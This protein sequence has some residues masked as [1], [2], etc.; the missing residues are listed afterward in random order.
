MIKLLKNLAINF[1][2]K[3]EDLTQQVIHEKFKQYLK[4]MI[5]CFFIIMAI[6]I[7]NIWLHL[8]LLS[9][10]QL[11]LQLPL[12]VVVVVYGI[13][14]NKLGNRHHKIRMAEI[15]AAYNEIEAIHN[16]NEAPNIVMDSL[17]GIEEVP[18]EENNYSN[19]DWLNIMMG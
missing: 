7:C 18:N 2:I 11:F 3:D 5:F 10:L 13:K 9:I 17:N 15:V 6:P 19:D 12:N 4:V 14:L 16:D 1:D 8:I